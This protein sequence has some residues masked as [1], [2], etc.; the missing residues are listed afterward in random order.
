MIQLRTVRRGE[1]VA[2]WN[3]SGDVRFVDG[4]RRLLLVRE[5]VQPLA[6]YRA[7]SDEYLVVRMRNG[8]TEHRRGP[9]DIWFNPVEHESIAIEKA[10][11]IDAHESLV[12]YERQNE[13]A[14]TRR[15]LKGPAQYVPQANE[16]LHKFCWHGT[17]PL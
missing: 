6:H 2:V 10:I 14:V 13:E 16:W 9:A 4:P 8:R 1:R 3:R 17:D 7:E 5:R 12:V 15:V 11:P